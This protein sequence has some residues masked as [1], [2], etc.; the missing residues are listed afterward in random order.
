[1]NNHFIGIMSGTSFD[2]VDAV[3][4]Y[5]EHNKIS[6]VEHHTMPYPADL[7]SALIDLSQPG[8]HN[9][10]TLY[11]ADAQLGDL[12]GHTVL[13][14]L[15]KA[16]IG[17]SS[18]QAIGLHGQTIR[19]FPN[20]RPA[21]SSQLGDPNRVVALTGITTIC[22]FRRADIA[23]GG[24]GAPLA[25]A[26]H[27]EFFHD[28]QAER[29]IVNIG[30]FSNITL[31]PRDRTVFGF[32]TG[33]GNVLLDSYMQAYCDKPFDAA[34]GLASKGHVSKACLSDLLSHPYF[35]APF[36]KSTGRDEFN[37][38]AIQSQLAAHKLNDADAMAT[39][40]E[41]TACTIADAIK[42]AQPLTDQVFVCGGGAKNVYLMSRLAALLPQAS[43]EITD[44]IGVLHGLV[45]PCL[46]AWLAQQTLGHHPVDLCSITGANKASILGGIYFAR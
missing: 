1:M 31:L 16:N 9:L 36:P 41:L 6:V 33:P 12:Y 10:E 22:D 43:C 28:T 46:M 24:Q 18:I 20:N 34:G 44:K 45:E 42:Q 13:S 38:L 29:V 17:I 14:L 25:P 32:D 4:A 11:T 30:G 39:L 35:K 19:H 2:T 21:F 37:L 5:F 40:T 27:R 23:H 15:N 3:I 26:F 7:R 8:L